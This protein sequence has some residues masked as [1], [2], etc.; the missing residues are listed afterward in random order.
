ML[1]IA[2]SGE[3][4]RRYMGEFQEGR[5]VESSEPFCKFA[6]SVE[7]TSRIPVMISTAVRRSP[8]SSGVPSTHDLH[9]HAIVDYTL[10]LLAHPMMGLFY[11][12]VSQICVG[13]RAWPT[14]R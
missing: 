6:Y 2:G 11:G 13:G 12:D 7:D 8:S 10:V 9:L 14:Q 4:K 1:L 5:Q 3:S